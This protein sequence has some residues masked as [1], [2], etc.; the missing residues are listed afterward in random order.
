MISVHGTSVSVLHVVSA[1]GAI[2]NS[3]LISFNTNVTLVK[4]VDVHLKWYTSVLITSNPEIFVPS[5]LSTLSSRL[6]KPCQ[7]PRVR[8]RPRDVSN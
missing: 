4:D 7:E 8:S 3:L 5:A 2:D 1:T 6:A